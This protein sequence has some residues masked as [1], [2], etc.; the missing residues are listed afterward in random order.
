VPHDPSHPLVSFVL[1]THNRR[2][3]VADTLC[4]VAACGLAR[5]RFEIIVVDNASSGGTAQAISPVCDMLIRLDHNGG[6]CAKAQGMKKARGRYVVLLDDDSYP[7]AGSVERM[8]GHFDDDEKLAAAGFDVRL[9]DGGREGA[10]LPHVFV[11]CG[12]G[13]RREALVACGNL[14]ATFF[15]QAEEY[16]LSFR[17]A[18]AGWSIRCFDDL[19]VT[20]RKTAT[21]RD[22]VRTIF[23]DTRNNLRVIARYLSGEALTAYREDC[24]Q[25]YAWLAEQHGHTRAFV[26]GAW[27]GLLRGA[28]DRMTYQNR[29]LSAEAFE[30]FFQWNRIERRMRDM[31]AEGIRQVLFVGFGK[32]VYAYFRAARRA[33]LGISA[34]GDDRFAAPARTYRGVPVIPFEMA[35]RE[36]GDAIVV[37]DS[38][39]VHGSAMQNMV[40]A[41]TDLPVEHVAAGDFPSDVDGR[42]TMMNRGRP[43]PWSVVR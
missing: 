33:G 32:N 43:R 40:R 30:C 27:T 16:D 23:L 8:I 6:S 39:P 42:S 17:L 11:G 28:V 10:A 29:R 37:A 20:H 26:R 36:P 2:E 1:A 24:L 22:S 35:L 3:I 15:M 18:A 34:I 14:D 4:R 13:L 41:A 21:A 31:A 19:H 12:V 9:T 38:S 25:R 7:H 5:S